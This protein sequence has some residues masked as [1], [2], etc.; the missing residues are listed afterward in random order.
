MKKNKVLLVKASIYKK[1]ILFST[2]FLPMS[3]NTK[4]KNLKISKEVHSTLKSYC[5]K[6]GLTM[7]KFIEKMIM[8]KCAIKK[9]VY[10][11][12]Y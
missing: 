4:I 5:D 10:G 3:N 6:N 12:E 11:E 8:D 1:G 9:D 2:F 7:Y